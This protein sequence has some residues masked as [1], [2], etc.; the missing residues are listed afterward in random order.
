[1]HKNSSLTV[2]HF[3]SSNTNTNIDY[4]FRMD[5]EC[6]YNNPV[7]DRVL[8]EAII[9]EEIDSVYLYMCTNND[10]C[11]HYISLLKHLG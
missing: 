2:F 5:K 7:N 9:Q 8:F 6:I 4:S 3:E 11:H 1:M 10:N